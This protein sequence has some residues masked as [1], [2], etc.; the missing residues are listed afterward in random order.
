ME[1]KFNT[2]IDPN[3]NESISLYSDVAKTHLTNYINK[4]KYYNSNESKLNVQEGC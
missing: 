1:N 2:M 3:T 4:M